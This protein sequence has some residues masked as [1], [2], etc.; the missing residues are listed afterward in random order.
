MN[1]ETAVRYAGGV[2]A[3]AALLGVTKQAVSQWGAQMPP[4]RVF[5]LRQLK[6]GWFRRKS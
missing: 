1:K 4:L 6:P 3:L 2:S 5:Q